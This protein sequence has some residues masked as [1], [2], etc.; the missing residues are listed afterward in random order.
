MERFFK[1]HLKF[2]FVCWN[3]KNRN[4][5]HHA[6]DMYLDI[7]TV[8]NVNW[9]RHSWSVVTKNIDAF[10]NASFFCGIQATMKLIF[11][12]YVFDCW[13]AITANEIQKKNFQNFFSILGFWFSYLQ[14]N[15]IKSYD[16]HFKDKGT[17][18][19]N[20]LSEVIILQLW[21]VNIKSYTQK[22][23]RPQRSLFFITGGL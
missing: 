9:F 16:K 21:I 10:F 12:F 4:I 14:K 5:P 3:Y 13:F 15:K 18:R 7:A 6:T 2:S 17:C 1:D 22:T 23:H 19:I 20:P 8:A 11:P